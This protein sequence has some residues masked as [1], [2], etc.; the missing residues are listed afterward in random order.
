MK[1][2]LFKTDMIKAIREGRKTVTRR[3]IK[4]K[5]M[6]LIV[7]SDWHAPWF[8][9]VLNE[10]VFSARFGLA[11]R[12]QRIK[13]RYHIGETVYIKEAWCEDFTGEKI[14]YKLDGGESPG[15]QIFFGKDKQWHDYKKPFW[16]SP[17]F[18]PEIFA[19]Y[20]IQILD[21]RPE[22]PQEITAE[23]SYKEG[24]EKLDKGV[25]RLN[26]KYS[27]ATE[28]YAELWNSINPKHP[29]SSNPW[30]WRYEFKLLPDGR[31]IN[32]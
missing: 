20:F 3:V 28:L 4:F 23:E 24:I 12:S 30:V 8:D 25:G 32:G 10:W 15:A 29:F 18:L 22:R 14:H 21:V 2:I 16:R 5:S 31:S 17:L 26:Y 1:G 7:D 19:R 13:P 9:I 27:M 6:P 11:A